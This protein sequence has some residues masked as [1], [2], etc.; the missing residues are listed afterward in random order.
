MLKTVLST[1][2]GSALALRAVGI[3]TEDVR[4]LQNTRIPIWSVVLASVVVGGFIVAR[5]APQTWIQGLREIGK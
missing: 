1:P 5:Y 3:S 2:Q 4:T